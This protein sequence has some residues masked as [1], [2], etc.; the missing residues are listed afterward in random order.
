MLSSMIPQEVSRW[1]FRVLVGL[2]VG[3]SEKVPESASLNF[4]MSNTYM[5]WKPWEEKYLCSLT[6][7]PFPTGTRIS[8]K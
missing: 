7:I 3:F 5:V 1:I 8:D 2:K 6:Q 4:Q